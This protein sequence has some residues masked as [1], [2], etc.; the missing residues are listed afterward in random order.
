MKKDYGLTEW[1]VKY[2]P[3]HYSSQDKVNYK[4]E[5]ITFAIALITIVLVCAFIKLV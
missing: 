4:K 1:E 2:I 5:I 3:L